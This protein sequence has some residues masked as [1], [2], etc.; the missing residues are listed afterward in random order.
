M[1]L[2]VLILKE[3]ELKLDADVVIDARP[4]HD[5][6]D[7]VVL[8]GRELRSVVA[9]GEVR[10]GAIVGWGKYTGRPVASLLDKALYIRAIPLSLYQ[11]LGYLEREL[12]TY[13][14]KDDIKIL[15]EKLKKIIVEERK[16]YKKSA[17]LL[18]LQKFID[19]EA[20]LPGYLA[21]ILGPVDRESVAKI[22]EILYGEIY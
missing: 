1:S 16:K 18:A 17:S 3:G 19:G 9:V 10:G 11:E 14:K 20:Q 15:V 21:D 12:L 4:P 5:F 8:E 6:Y 7:V 13:N 2:K 22:L